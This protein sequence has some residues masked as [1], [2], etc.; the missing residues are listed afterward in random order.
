METERFTEIPAVGIGEF[1]PGRT[2]SR[3]ETEN[4]VRNA[5]KRGDRKS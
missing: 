2:G 1:H 3:G 4:I 5:E